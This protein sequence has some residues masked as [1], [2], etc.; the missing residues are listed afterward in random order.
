MSVQDRDWLARRAMS[1]FQKYCCDTSGRKDP[2]FEDDADDQDF[3]ALAQ[4]AASVEPLVAQAGAAAA[5][6][7]AGT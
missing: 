2:H 7:S 1:D 3:Q 5:S 6:S 4:A